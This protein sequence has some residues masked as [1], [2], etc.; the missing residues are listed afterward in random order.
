MRRVHVPLS[1]TVPSAATSSAECSNIICQ[2]QQHHLPSTAT[3]STK[4]KQHHLP[5]AAATSAQCM[6]R[7]MHPAPK[8]LHGND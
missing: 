1:A 5:S 7:L 4:C 3:S 2:V 6:N 8:G